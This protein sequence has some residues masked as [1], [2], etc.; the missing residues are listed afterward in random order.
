VQGPSPSFTQIIL[1]HL[2]QFGAI[3]SRGWRVA[4]QLHLRRARSSGEASDNEGLVVISRL[5]IAL[6]RSDSAVEAPCMA[7]P[8]TMVIFIFCGCC[9]GEVERLPFALLDG[10]ASESDIRDPAA[11]GGSFDDDD[12]EPDAVFDVEGIWIASGFSFNC[13][14]L[15]NGGSFD[16]GPCP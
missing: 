11:D 12:D 7:L 1:P 15:A 10:G 13:S 4:I 2:V 16:L 8:P 5:R 6:S 3:V 14:T 9:A